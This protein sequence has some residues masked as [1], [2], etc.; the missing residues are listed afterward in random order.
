M[1]KKTWI[2]FI[3]CSNHLSASFVIA[4]MKG[5]SFDATKAPRGDHS[6]AMVHAS[7]DTKPAPRGDNFRA[8]MRLSYNAKPPPRDEKIRVMVY[9]RFMIQASYATKS[10]P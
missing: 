8:L 2:Y 3:F 5:T 7:H 1:T 6:R 4:A 9:T 10:A